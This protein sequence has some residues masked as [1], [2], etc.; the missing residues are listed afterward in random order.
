MT[1]LMKRRKRN[2][3]SPFDNRLLTPWSNSLL[4]PWRSRL[5]PSNFDDFTNLTRFDDIFKDDFFEDDSLLPAMNVKEHE[6]DFEIEFAA[7]GFNKK[8]FEVTIEEN[9]LHL[10]GEKEVEEEEKEDDYSRKE[11]SYKSFKRSMMLPPSVDLDQ[12]I[13]ASYK[14]G[15]LKVKLL[16]KE[17]AIVQ[18]PP[19]KVI[20]VN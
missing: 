9:V 3:L 16:K 4:S 20:E 19:K 1:T 5:F 17:E 15:I 6:E 8:D 2:R 18:Q 14:N 13:K 12:D 11:F 10:S 7:P